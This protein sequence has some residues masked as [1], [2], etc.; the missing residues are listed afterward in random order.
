MCITLGPAKLSKTVIY[1]G[2]AF[3][4]ETGDYIHVLG[5]QNKAENRSGGPNAMVL[6]VPAVNLGADNMVDM[7]SHPNVLRDMAAK[8]KNDFTPEV[9]MRSFGKAVVFCKGN[10]TVAI[11]SD[12]TDLVP[13]LESIPEGVRPTIQPDLLKAY[14]EWYP[15]WPLA[16]CCWDGEI[17]AEPLLWWYQPLVKNKLFYPAVDSH[18]GKVPNLKRDAKRDHT[19][20]VGSYITQVGRD[21]KVDLGPASKFISPVAWGRQIQEP[22]FN[23]DY[24][25][26]VSDLQEVTAEY[27]LWD[28]EFAYHYPSWEL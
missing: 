24:K 23:R 9:E 2:E 7:T 22:D 12:A 17:E 18:N 14:A 16:V 3:H 19:L 8:F 27:K 1:A 4:P 5:Y 21:T 20:L 15:N 26:D 13:A 10:Y 28:I 25:V 11:A 6:P